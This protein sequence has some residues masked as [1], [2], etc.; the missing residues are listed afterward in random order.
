MASPRTPTVLQVFLFRQGEFLGT[1]VFAE[2]QVSIGREAPLA[3][4]VLASTDVSRR[5]ALIEHDGTHVVV[6]DLGSTNGIYVNSVKVEHAEVSRLDEIAIGE[7]SLKVKLVGGGARS[8]SDKGDATVAATAAEKRAADPMAD[9]D[10]VSG[11][12]AAPAAPMTPAPRLDRAAFG[13]MLEGIGIAPAPKAPKAPKP[14]PPVARARKPVVHDEQPEPDVERREPVAPASPSSPSLASRWL[15]RMTGSPH[16]A[17]APAP[18]ALEEQPDQGTVVDFAPSAPAPKPSPQPVSLSTPDDDEAEEAFVPSY[19]LAD[20]L[21]ADAPGVTTHA[22]GMEQRLVCVEV[23][24]LRGDTVVDV[25]HLE[26]G[27]SFWIGPRGGLWPWRRAPELP[28]RL[29]FLRYRRDGKCVAQVREQTQGTLVRAGKTLAVSEIAGRRR[30]RGGKRT[31]ELEPRDVL[32]VTMGSCRYQARFIY[33]PPR[34][35]DDRPLKERLKPSPL[36]QRALGGSFAGHL[37]ALILVGVVLP[38]SMQQAAMAADEFVEVILEPEVKLEDPPP[39]PEPEPEAAPSAPEVAPSQAPSPKKRVRAGGTS[40]A[41][42]GVLGLLSKRGSSAAPGPAAAV[43]AVSNLTAASAPSGTSGFRVSGLIGKLPTSDL[44]VGGGGGGV[45]TKGGT[46]LLRGGGGGAGQLSGK[47]TRQV[48]G[49]VQKVPQ[50]MRAVGQGTL[51]RDAIQ[52]VINENISQVQRCY[53]RELIQNSG[54]SG[55]I[56]VEWTIGTS[57]SVRSARQTFSSLASTGVATCIMSAIRSWRFPQPKGGE[58]VVNYPFIF[59][60]IGF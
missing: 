2:R 44:S 30:Q 13:A 3:D 16:A 1:E 34:Q 58:V 23:L 25:T 5:H 22:A 38:S 54:L 28:P 60:S 56:Q 11:E 10:D 9:W 43:A 42:P 12:R 6:K 33:A 7:F 47:G 51:D 45:V 35:R 53:E 36:T 15:R 59:K 21:V 50:A 29:R 46:A 48:G 27:S 24:T 41:P 20:K 32:E 40:K 49:L 17:R 57:G 39:E 8:A 26:H 19:S 52:K 55:K 4:L 14:S 37:L 18:R 31:V